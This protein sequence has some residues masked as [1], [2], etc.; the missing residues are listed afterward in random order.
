MTPAAGGPPARP[1]IGP[2]DPCAGSG[3]LHCP[4]PGDRSAC[5]GPRVGLTGANKLSVD[6]QQIPVFP[7]L[8]GDSSRAELQHIA[9]L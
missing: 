6:R 9:A 8:F 1:Q 2:R 7:I 3:V 4:D 5:L